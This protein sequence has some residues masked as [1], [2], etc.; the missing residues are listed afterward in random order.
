M[1]IP[2]ALSLLVFAGCNS[3]KVQLADPVV[4]SMPVK[5]LK[6]GSQTTYVEYPASVKG[7]VDLEVRPQ[8]AGLLETIYV[9]EGAQVFKGQTL[10]KINDLPYKEALNNATANLQAAKAAVLNAQIEVEKLTP[11]VSAKV[12]SEFQLRSARAAHQIAIANVEQAR[13]GVS[14]AKINLSYTN[15][16]SPVDGYVGRLPK[17]QG[18]VVGPNDPVALTELSDAHDVHVYFSL[19][20]ADFINFNNKY[21]GKTISARLKALPA[22]SLILSDGSVY[23]ENGRVDMV[24]GQFDNQTGAI[25]LRAKFANHN[26]ILRSGNTGKIRLPVH[27]ENVILVPRSATVEIQDKIFVYTV[28]AKN[29]VGRK[30]IAVSATSGEEYLVN[31]GL[32]SGE[33]IV[34]DGIDKLKDG[35]IIVPTNPNNQTIA[36]ATR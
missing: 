27:H 14:A 5:L 16:K 10:F 24:D 22:V 21:P 7:A 28:D 18:S 17:K 34:V 30:P 11:L 13:A 29:T 9:N 20:E 19:G 15:I 3:E 1:K 25:T 36:T 2:L 8:I 6:N 35:D 23:S 33:R 12:V 4:Q 26:G 31:S 32:R